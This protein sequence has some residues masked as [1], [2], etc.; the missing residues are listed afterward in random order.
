MKSIH[1]KESTFQAEG[2]ACVMGLRQE[3][4]Y[5]VHS[6]KRR[7]YGCQDWRKVAQEEVG[8]VQKD[9]IIRVL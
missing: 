7:Q 8:E 6:P 5:L 1:E 2:Q 4:A 9:Q 3:R